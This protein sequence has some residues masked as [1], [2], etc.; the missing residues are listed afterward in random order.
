MTDLLV[1]GID[2]S[3]DALEALT[4]AASFS[5]MLGAR[6]LPVHVLPDR[7]GFPYGDAS[8]R[9][10]ARGKRIQTIQA[11][12]GST[13]SEGGDEPRAPLQVEI[14]RPAERLSAVARQQGAAM[15]VVGSRGR[16][17]LKRALL[18]SVSSELLRSSPCPVLVV[19]PGA[20]GRAATRWSLRPRSASVLCGVDGS[21][22]SHAA[23]AL[24]S[25]LASRMGTRLVLAHAYRPGTRT[26]AHRRIP[27]RYP[28]RLW[29]ARQAGL[30]LLEAAERNLTRLP[31]PELELP[32]GDPARALRRVASRERAEL[33]VVGS[34]GRGSIGT[35]LHGSSAAA[36]AAAAPVPVLVVPS[37]RS[38]RPRAAPKS[39][40]VSTAS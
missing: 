2:E 31:V 36:L 11:I 32:L 28:A 14:G 33:I 6:L 38:G 15:L 1:C 21:S 3:T 19:P 7:P 20:V 12:L 34:R 30:R 35:A 25:E 26:R 23:A 16:G 40:S 29:G 10:R 27:M 4:V 22:E 37:S 18:G 8:A 17:P 24:A 13:T 9:E 39:P 5:E